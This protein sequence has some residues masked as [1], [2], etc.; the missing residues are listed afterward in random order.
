M[1]GKSVRAVLVAL[2]LAL[3]IAMNVQSVTKTNPLTN[4]QPTPAI[5]VE[6]HGTTGS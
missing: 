2:L 3:V 6:E 4:Q 1:S 5:L